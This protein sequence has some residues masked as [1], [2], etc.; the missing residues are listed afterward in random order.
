MNDNK[1]I[2]EGHTTLV[3]DLRIMSKEHTAK[4]TE[5][6]NLKLEQVIR[7]EYETINP[8]FQLSVVSMRNLGSMGEGTHS[9]SIT[10]Q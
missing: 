5:L 1:R 7:Y 4:K 8:N 6:A 9:D 10:F 2:T 3:N